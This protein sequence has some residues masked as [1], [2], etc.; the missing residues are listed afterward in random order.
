V[1]FLAL[2]PLTSDYLAEAVDLDQ[3]CLGGLWA[4]DGY[5]REIDSPNS[6]LLMLQHFTAEPKH[7]NNEFDPF[8]PPSPP[9]IIGLACAWAI[10]DEAHITL[11]AIDPAHRRQ[12]F[13]QV[14][15]YTLL[16]L[17]R[18]RGMEW[19]TLE[20]RVSNQAAISLYQRLG[21]ETVGERPHYYQNPP[22]NALIL[23]RQGLQRAAFAAY[24]QQWRQQLEQ[25]LAQ[26]GWHWAAE[27]L[28]RF[29]THLHDD[30]TP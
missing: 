12:G 11:L 24:L 9:S 7:S 26:T 6:D 15:L 13:A 17:A 18:D 29:K 20:V 30:P 21:F 8:Q 4:H 14:L 5:Q 3:R 25:R 23:W 1:N 22:E 2:A 16:V 19:A 10:L 27:G 28:P